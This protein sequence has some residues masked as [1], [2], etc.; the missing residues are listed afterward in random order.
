MQKRLNQVYLLFKH[1]KE[2]KGKP[3]KYLWT[4]CSIRKKKKRCQFIKRYKVQIKFNLHQIIRLYQRPTPLP[5]RVSLINQRIKVKEK[6][7]DQDLNPDL[8]QSKNQ[9]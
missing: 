6:E 4:R 2:D 7:V 5:F 8:N 3:K 9:I 1:N